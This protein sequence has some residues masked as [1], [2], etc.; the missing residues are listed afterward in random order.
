M[1]KYRND[2][3]LFVILMFILYFF[4]INKFMF[5]NIDIVNILFVIYPIS[6]FI[7]STIEARYSGNFYV[8]PIVSSIF[9]IP[10]A[11]TIYDVSYLACFFIYLVIGLLGGLFG[12]W[13]HDNEEVRKSF[14]KAIG[15]VSIIGIIFTTAAYFLNIYLSKCLDYYCRV[16]DFFTASSIQSLM[17]IGLMI[18]LAWFCFRKKGKK[19]KDKDGEK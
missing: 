14:K 16:S 11:F 6:F 10:L 4:S 9:Y 2:L 18:L 17:A 3:Y 19:K 13:C 12:L 7:T 5:K 8:F 15:V 1:K